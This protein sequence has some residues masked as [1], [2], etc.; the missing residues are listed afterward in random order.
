MLLAAT[1]QLP[2][3][4]LGRIQ[5]RETAKEVAALAAALEPYK[6]HCEETAVDI[7]VD[8]FR[9]VGTVGRFHRERSELLWWRVG[10]IRAKD[11]VDAWLRLLA[12]TCAVER[13]ITA[14]LLGSK[15]NAPLIMNG[16]TPEQSR[17]H[18][19]RW[20]KTWTDG[21]R[22]PLPF[23]PHT[24]LTWVTK[25]SGAEAAWNQSYD[26]GKDDYHR[27]VFA[28]PPITEAFRSLAGDLLE[29]LVEAMQ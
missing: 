20:L 18:L 17:S 7:A 15:T 25:P 9:I 2:P 29:P 23:F 27:M 1:G 6:S 13:R 4:N 26:D 28:D 5:Y 12:L 3:D 19:R 14:Y 8:G 10:D 22:A 24:S 11:K 16:P 21:Q